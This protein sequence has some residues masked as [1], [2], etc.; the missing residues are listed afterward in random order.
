MSGP[1]PAVALQSIN[2]F[3][4]RD[5]EAARAFEQLYLETK[6][7]LLNAAGRETFEAVS[8]LQAVRKQP[9]TPAAGAD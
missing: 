1:N 6:D 7:S 3:Q 5:A 4:V 8:V 2:S 9:Y